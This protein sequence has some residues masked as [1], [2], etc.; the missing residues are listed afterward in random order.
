M[1]NL[2][3]DNKAWFCIAREIRQGQTEQESK[4]LNL[5]IKGAAPSSS[6]NDKE[7]VQKLAETIDIVLDSADIETQRIG[8]I[9][10]QNGNQI[11]HVKFKSQIKRKQF[12][13]NSM[14]LRDNAFYS[15]VFVDLD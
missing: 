7:C 11:L 13:R 2:T 6:K 5:G 8:N 15:T 10:E 9:S 1:D 3:K 14:K 12:L 4:M